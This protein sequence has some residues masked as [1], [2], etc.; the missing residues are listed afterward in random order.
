MSEEL[1]K[2]AVKAIREHYNCQSKYPSENLTIVS[3]G[4]IVTLP[5][6]V[7]NVVRMNSTKVIFV[8]LRIRRKQNES[9]NVIW[10]GL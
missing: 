10:T 3:L 6:I 9:K 5:M 8:R 2:D 4:R 7:V 1:N